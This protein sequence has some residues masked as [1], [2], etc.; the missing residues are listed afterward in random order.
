MYSNLHDLAEAKR[1]ALMTLESFVLESLR[2]A[3]AQGFFL[4]GEEINEKELSQALKTSRM[5]IRQAIAVLEGEGLLVRIPRRG[6]FVTEVNAEIV[7]EIYA[8]RIEL[9]ALA[10]RRA[11]P[12]M[13]DADIARLI[14]FTAIRPETIATIQQH[15]E[16]NHAFHEA[17][18]APCNWPRLLRQI[19]Q[20]RTAIGVHLIHRG[21]FSPEREEASIREHRAL[22][23]ACHNRDAE[24]AEQ[25]IRQHNENAK[26]MFVRYNL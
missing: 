10:V 7:E 22:V 18:Y 9:E 14:P 16:M 12:R 11:V 23:D 1:G 6:T 21:K 8:M 26:E 24:R 17:L 13:T 2:E 5:P 19:Q 15:I 4:P 20:L 25:L 3:L